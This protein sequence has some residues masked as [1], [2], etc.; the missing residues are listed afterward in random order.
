M[1]KIN[2]VG[3][4]GL[5]N[6]GLKIYK[7]IVK[8]FP[9]LKISC[10]TV[11]TGKNLKFTHQNFNIYKNWKTMLSNE[12]LDFIFVAVPPKDNFIIFKRVLKKKIPLFIEKPMT[13]DI[14]EA[15]KM[16]GIYK[17]YKNIVHVNHI[18][19]FNNAVQ[20]LL[21]KQIKIKK[22]FFQ[23]TSPSIGK[24]Y[25]SP[26]FDLAPH[27]LAVILSFFKNEPKTLCANKIYISKKVKKILKKKRELINL[28]MKFSE[29][30]SAEIIVGN[31]TLK[32]IRQAK[33][34]T[35]KKVFFYNNRSKNLLTKIEKNGKKISQKV[36][37]EPSLRSSIDYFI[38]RKIKKDNDVKLGAKILKIMNLSIESLKKKRELQ[39]N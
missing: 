17:K 7:T 14:E 36:E 2:K 30:R 5:G 13:T 1:K 24:K 38:K 16:L 18:D 37:N 10:V 3:I 26:F 25:I 15:K 35:E 34:F 32:K 39:T 11:K 31:G 12:K 8:D 21:K 19:L 27:P 20:L 33:F 9:N 22:I 4:I 28:K 23:I 29:G 6:W